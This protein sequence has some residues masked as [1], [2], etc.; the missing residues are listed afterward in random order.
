MIQFRKV[1][2][3]LF[4]IFLF[5]YMIRLLYVTKKRWKFKTYVFSIL[6]CGLGFVS[7]A[8]FLD[9]I[10]EFVQ[11][12][13]I[14]IMIQNFFTLGAIIYV[15]GIILWT[16]FTIEIMNKLQVL[17][18]TDSMTGALNRSGI[19]KIYESAASSQKPFYVVVCDLNGTKRINDTYGHLEGDKYINKTTE[20]ITRAIGSKGHLA[21]TGGDEFV[22]L[23]EYV[24]IQ[25]IKYIISNIK[26]QVYEINKENNTGISIGYSVFPKDGTT[27]EE[28]IKVADQKMYEDKKKQNASRG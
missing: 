7:I 17:T 2:V 28:L 10:E 21:R 24:E 14:E 6:I 11:L 19:D 3:F 18:L 5:I 8:T 22:I 15:I 4:V 12:Q 13:F 20:I 25:D 16:R 1:V 23:L 9:M 26:K 27:L